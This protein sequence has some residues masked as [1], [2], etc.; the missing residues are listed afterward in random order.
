MLAAFSPGSDFKRYYRGRMPRLALIVIILMPLMYGAL[1]L[2]A[3]W[4]PFNAVDKIPVALVNADVGTTVQGNKLDAGAQV[5]QGL[6]DSKQLDLHEVSEKEAAE[7]VRCATASTTSRSRCRRTSVSR[8]PLPR[9]T[10]R[11]LHD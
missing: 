5:A 6:I 7:G 4:N 3:F 11:T 8:S 9:A 10:I 2:W 1:Y